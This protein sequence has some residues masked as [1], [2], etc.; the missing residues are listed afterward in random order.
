MNLILA[1]S[2]AAAVCTAIAGISHLTMLP[3]FNMNSTM[4]FLV[5]GIAQYFGYS[6]YQTMGQDMGL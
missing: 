4:L 3:A 5:G 1:L 6:N 2:I